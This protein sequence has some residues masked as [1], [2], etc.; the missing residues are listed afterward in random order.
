MRL[1]ASVS[2]TSAM[3]GDHRD[4]NGETQGP[5]WEDLLDTQS[6][7]FSAVYGSGAAGG[8]SG[9][10]SLAANLF[11]NRAQNHFLFIDYNEH[12]RRKDNNEVLDAGASVSMVGELPNLTKLISSSNFYYSDK[13]FPTSGFSSN[14][15]SQQDFSIRQSFMIDM[16]RAFSDDIA[17]EISITWNFNRM[18]YSPPSGASSLHDQ[19]SLNVINRWNWYAAERFTLRSGIDYRFISLDSTEIGNRSRHDGGVYTT[20]ELSPFKQTL[21]IPSVKAV[22]TNNR[23]AVIPKFGILWNVTEALTVRNNY[24]RSFKFPDF[25]ELYWVG[26]GN[27]GNPDLLPEDGWGVDIGAAWS[28][29]ILKLESVF[30]IQ[31]IQNSIHW[32]SGSSAAG[33]SSGIWQPENV[34][35]A[36][37]MGFDAKIGLDIPIDIGVVKKISPSISYKYLQ[38][39]LLSFDYTYESDKRIPYNPEHTFGFSFDIFWEKGSIFIFGHYESVRYNDRANLTMLNPYFLLN[40]AV[41][42][43]ITEYFT[44]FS[45]LRNILNT[46]YE[47]FYDYPMPGITLTLGLRFCYDVKN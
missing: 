6:Y 47:S 33:G 7:T 12:T 36:M 15:G 9:A 18:D 32:Y 8:S 4:R 31:W 16:P 30:F 20:L 13:N 14:Y 22:F 41:N 5:N 34:G 44:V 46:S 40:A 37:F 27:F 3:P 24:F 26:G 39:Y 42:Q 19:N 10:F 43:K 29:N 2:N 23:I 25:E 1:T 17:S 38:S 45:T 11:A 28:K 21:F 35:E